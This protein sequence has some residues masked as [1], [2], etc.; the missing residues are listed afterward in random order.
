MK[1]ERKQR[2]LPLA[3]L[4]PIGVLAAVSFFGELAPCLASELS[5]QLGRRRHVIIG[6]DVSTSMKS[7]AM[8]SSRMNEVKDFLLEILYKRLPAGVKPPH[9]LDEKL[10][11]K[12]VLRWDQPLYAEGDTLTCFSFA[13]SVAYHGLRKRKQFVSRSDLSKYLPSYPQSFSGRSTFLETAYV[14]AYDNYESRVDGETFLVLVSD[15]ERDRKVYWFSGNW[16]DA[17]CC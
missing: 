5:S 7:G 16:T 9:S 2:K 12:K 8:S 13:E 6:I 11:N 3:A 1:T 10:F 14:A 4:L 15:M 17:H